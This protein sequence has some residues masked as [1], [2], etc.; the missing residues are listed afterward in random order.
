MAREANARLEISLKAEERATAATGSGGTTARLPHE[1]VFVREFPNGTS[2]G[3]IDR[4]WSTVAGSVTAGAAV[5]VDVVGSL[6]SKLD[7]GNTVSFIDLQTM[8]IENTATSGNLLVGG[9]T[10]AVGLHSAANDVTVI[11]PGGCRVFD[12]GTAGLACVAA[13]SD[14]L[15]VDASAGTVTYKVTVIGRSA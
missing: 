5:T 15:K 1:H 4:V 3:Q 7:S 13:T 12:F 9:A 10:N 14:E 8:I 2:D 6:T 11:Q